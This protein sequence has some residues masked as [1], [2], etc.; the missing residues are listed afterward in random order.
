MNDCLI[1]AEV[2]EAEITEVCNWREY[3]GG[4]V[5]NIW[6][7]NKALICAICGLWDNVVELIERVTEVEKLAERT[8]CIVDYI[9]QGIELEIGE[10]ETDN[11]YVVIGRAHV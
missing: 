7:M 11:S 10:E 5:Q 3:M 8:D 4:L 2:D 1:G 9:S 6:T